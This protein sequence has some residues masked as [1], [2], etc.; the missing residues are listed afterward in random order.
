MVL[1][2]ITKVTVVQCLVMVMVVV[3]VVVY[4]GVLYI[5]PWAP[6]RSAIQN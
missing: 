1:V 4:E 5:P 3:V 2:E 6:A